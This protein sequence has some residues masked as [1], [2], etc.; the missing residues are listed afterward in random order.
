MMLSRFL[1]LGAFCAL[2]PDL[3]TPGSAFRRL[4]PSTEAGRFGSEGRNAVRGPGLSNIDISGAE[5]PS[6]RRKGAAAIPRRVFQRRQSRELR[7]TGQ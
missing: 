6:S 5:E 1:I 4:N 2:S 7:D 3:W